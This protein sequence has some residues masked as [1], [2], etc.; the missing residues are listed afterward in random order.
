MLFGNSK[1]H[2]GA[3]AAWSIGY[4]FSC[5]VKRREIESRKGIGTYIL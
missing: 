5:G 2:Y 3:L 4:A 1:M